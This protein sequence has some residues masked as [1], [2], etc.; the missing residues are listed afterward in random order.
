LI[1]RLLTTSI[2]SCVSLSTTFGDHARELDRVLLILE[3]LELERAVQPVVGVVVE[4]LAVERQRP[5]VVHDLR[6]KSS[7]R[8]SGMSI[9]SSIERISRSSGSSSLPV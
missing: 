2:F 7:L 6:R 5:D 9:F 3:Q 8:D 4:L 1:S